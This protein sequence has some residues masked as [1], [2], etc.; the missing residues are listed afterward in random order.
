MESRLLPPRPNLRQYRKQA[1]DLLHAC[2]S[3]DPAALHSWAEQWFDATSD[4]WKET[5]SRLR[6]IPAIQ[7]LPDCVRREEIDRIEKR[8]RSSKLSEPDPKLADAQFFVAREHGFES[9]PKFAQQIQALHGGN[10]LA[11][12]F[13]AAADAITSGD[14]G[15]LR[16][17]LREQPELI[18]TRSERL[19]NSTLLHYVSANGIEDFRQKT[20]ANIVEIAR[21][22][23]DA[24]AEINAESNA[25]GGGCTAL[26]LVATSGHPE[27]A[28]VQQ[29]LMQLLLDQGAVIDKTAIEDCLSNGR[30]EAARFLASSGAPLNLAT[31]SGTGRLDVVRAFF[32]ADGSLK[33]TATKEQ[34]QR[35]FLWA[36]MYGSPEVVQFLLDRGADLSHQASVDATALH[37]AAAGGHL[38][39]V[40]LLIERGA[41]LEAINRWGGTVLEQAGWA[42]ANGDPDKDY[43]PIFD[44]LLA[45]GAKLQDGWLAWLQQQSG[46]QENAKARLAEVLRRH[47]ALS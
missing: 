42:F 2:V 37:W 28:G 20:P 41:P 7:N 43:V 29:A 40:H 13:E 47:G 46:R 5:E 3:T 9:W 1:K 30:G 33:S 17:L 31:A 11:A 12:K 39:I 10:S 21:L 6:G 19:H 16:R 18:H 36:S 25:Y 23:L 22:L 45:A 4:Q 32:D 24:G 8:V 27:R 14:I 26:G 38:G 15:T 35:G 44:A 34:L